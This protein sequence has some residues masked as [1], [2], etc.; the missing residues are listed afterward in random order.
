MIINNHPNYPF[1]SSNDNLN[2]LGKKFWKR[3][4]VKNIA[5][6]ANP[7]IVTKKL[8]V[9]PFRRSKTLRKVALVAGTAAAA[10]FAA[11]LVMKAVGGIGAKTAVG[12]AGAVASGAG[13][14]AS[15]QPEPE[16]G[17]TTGYAGEASASVP[18]APSP[19]L[20]DNVVSWASPAAQASLKRLSTPKTST[21]SQASAQNPQGAGLLSGTNIALI[22]GAGALAVG[23]YF[24]MRKRK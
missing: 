14:A 9:N 6:A 17:D 13:G 2:G 23:L 20:F 11:P 1:A 24:I 18:G 16:Y 10:Y 3:V 15:F 12:A 4:T 22:G 8:I 5:K 7:I 21:T 19:S